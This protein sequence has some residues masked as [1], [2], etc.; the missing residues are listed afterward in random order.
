MGFGVTVGLGSTMWDLGS[1]FGFWGHCGIWGQQCG[2]WGHCGI[3]VN[4]CGIWGQYCEI[5]GQHCGIWGQHLRDLGSTVYCG[6]SAVGLGSPHGCDVPMAAPPPPPMSPQRS[7]KFLFIWGGSAPTLNKKQKKP[8]KPQTDRNHKNPLPQ[9]PPK[10]LSPKV[11]R[12]N[13]DVYKGAVQYLQ[14]GGQRET[15]K[16][17]GAEIPK[18]SGGSQRTTGDPKEQWVTPKSNG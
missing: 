1:V 11:H 5:W 6:V 8:P 13:P 9:N 18:I 4:V 14:G 10:N 3:G 15:P 17:G 12:K 2:I 7:P 16:G